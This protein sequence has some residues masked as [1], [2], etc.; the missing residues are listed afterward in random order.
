MNTT[1]KRRHP[2]SHFFLLNEGGQPVPVYA[3][4]KESDTEAIPAL[5][6]DMSEGGVQVLTATDD[7]PEEDAYDLEIAH[8]EEI[9]PSLKAFRVVK[10]WQRRDGVNMRTGFAFRGE[11]QTVQLLQQCLSSAEHHLLRC[12]LHPAQV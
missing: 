12:V 5:L 3:F 7:S 10:A 6:L 2:R 9:A 1:D 11:P 8:A 4:R